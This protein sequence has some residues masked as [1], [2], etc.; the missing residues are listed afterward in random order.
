[1]RCTY[2]TGRS[3]DKTEEEE[4]CGCNCTMYQV[5]EESNSIIC[6]CYNVSNSVSCPSF[7]CQPEWMDYYEYDESVRERRSAAL[8][9]VKIIG[10]SREARSASSSDVAQSAEDHSEMIQKTSKH[11]AVQV[12]AHVNDTSSTVKPVSVADM[13]VELHR[14][15]ASASKPSEPPTKITFTKESATPTRLGVARVTGN[16]L[17]LTECHCNCLMDENLE[18]TSCYC[19]HKLCSDDSW[20]CSFQPSPLLG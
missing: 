12:M 1:V 10:S 20:L 9:S 4:A 11:A 13:F 5:A 2:W 3:A 14:S 18:W 19:D 8:E 16:S 15:K 7:E 17:K 6:D